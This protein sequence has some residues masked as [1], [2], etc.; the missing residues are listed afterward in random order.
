MKLM[1]ATQTIGD[2]ST[3]L[4]RARSTGNGVRRVHIVN[5]RTQRAQAAPAGA[6]PTGVMSLRVGASSGSVGA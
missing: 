2:T 6:H 3:P 4:H 1:S 5:A